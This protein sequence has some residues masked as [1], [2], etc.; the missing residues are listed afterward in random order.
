MPLIFIIFTWS[1]VSHRL[2]K[3]PEL[4]GQGR[5]IKSLEFEL[6]ISMPGIF[7]EIIDQFNHVMVND[8]G[9]GG[10]YFDL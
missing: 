2:G 10:I 1:A 3:S 7:L 9:P 5:F 4:I 6:N 8:P